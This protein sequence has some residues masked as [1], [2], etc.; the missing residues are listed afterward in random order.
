MPNTNGYG[1]KRAILHAR[2]Y[3]GPSEERILS[4]P[5]SHGRQATSLAQALPLAEM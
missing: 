5:A 2:F 4:G 3:R 1:S